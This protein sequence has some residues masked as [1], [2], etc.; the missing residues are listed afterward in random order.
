MTEKHSRPDVLAD[1]IVELATSFSLKTNR[2]AL[3][4]GLPLQNGVLAFETLDQAAERAGLKLSP[5][6]QPVN[7]LTNSCCPLL[8]ISHKSRQ[9]WVINQI[10]EVDGNLVAEYVLSDGS[11]GQKNLKQLLAEKDVEVFIARRSKSTDSRTDEI[12]IAKNP[13][14][15][16]SALKINRGIYGHIIVATLVVN[17]LALAVPLVTMN[18]YDRVVANAAFTT[19]WTLAIGAGL[20]ALFDLA[21]RTIRA[22]MID[23]ASARS[24]VMLANRI[25]ARLL[26]GRL[27]GR[28]SSVGVQANTLR[29]FESLREF[30]NSATIAALGDLPFLALFLTVMYVIS[31]PLVIIPLIAVPI[32]LTIG[33][34]SQ[35]KLDRIISQSFMEAAQKNAVV[36]E[37]LAGIE[38]I[39]SLAAESWA[40]SHWERSVASHLRHSLKSRFLMSISA[41]LVMFATSLTTIALL[42]FGVYEV[43]A[44]TITPGAMFAATIINGRI[45]GPL[46]QLAALLTRLHQA[47]MAFTALRQIVDLPQERTEGTSYLRKEK[48]DGEIAFD[49]VKFAYEEEAPDALRDISLS[50]RPRERV[51]IIGGVGSG[52]T[53]LM[54]LALG[55]HRPDDG[56]VLV[57]GLPVDQID[58]ANLRSSI[59]CLLQDGTLFHGDIRSNIT[60]NAPDASDDQLL[61]A[62]HIS[63]AIDW[64]RALPQGLDSHIGE[65]GAGLSGGQ[66]QT[67][68]LARALVRNPDI[69][70]L[71][72]PTSNMD[73]V[74]EKAFINRLSKTLKGKTLVLITHK[75]SL[76]ALVD[77]LIVMER[78]EI[79]LD[80][81]KADVMERLKKITAERQRKVA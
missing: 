48:F 3:L 44:G 27:R 71:D 66:K 13:H 12:P 10:S 80:G 24:D 56:K 49:R 77:R 5:W 68:C 73:G 23:R 30:F 79:L 1:A 75:P 45:M 11:V 35:R 81:P 17:L 2:Q 29:E 20:A 6:Q 32:V 22:I 8:A 25:F 51:G 69:L 21:L 26:G 31:G 40:A 64:I 78:G 34:L 59:G 50:I 52:K 57:D 65:R 70:L 14:W 4:H 60:L 72:E 58:P 62:L 43:T 15:F 16:W 46:G 9:A 39:K 7:G 33:Y 42:V 38:T 19:L 37:S 18:I 61:Q 76:L 63:G 36:V 47:R 28:Q 55:L 41:N 53:T 74:T 54:K 67:L